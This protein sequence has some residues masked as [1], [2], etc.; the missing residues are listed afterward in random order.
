MW[1]FRQGP[2][3]FKT[4]PQWSDGRTER[5]GR[6]M[7]DWGSELY[8]TVLRSDMAVCHDVAL[9]EGFYQPHLYKLMYM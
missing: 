8:Y 3:E 2:R 1:R 7:R 4:C 6:N 9:K 5:S